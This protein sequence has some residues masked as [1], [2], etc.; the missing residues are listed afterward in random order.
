M[1]VR[2]IITVITVLAVALFG[3]F[4]I[5]QLWLQPVRVESTSMQPSLSANDRVLVNVHAG[6][7][8][9]NRGDIVVVALEPHPPATAKFTGAPLNPDVRD[10]LFA[11]RTDGKAR[12]IVKRVV[13]LPGETVQA[14]QGVIVINNVRKLPE[15]YLR[16]SA[17]LVADFAPIVLRTDEYFVLGDNRSSSKDSRVFGPVPRASILGVVRARIWPPGS[18]GEIKR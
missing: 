16:G 8:H 14:T 10:Q 17:K 3:A 6:A 12:F 15:R 5:E 4:L 13:G 11:A 2:R 7:T 1:F 18:F 9:I